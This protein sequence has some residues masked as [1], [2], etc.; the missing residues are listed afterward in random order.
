MVTY[1]P[2]KEPR[3]VLLARFDRRYPDLFG[4]RDLEEHQIVKKEEKPRERSEP[5]PE[6]VPSYD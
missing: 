5:Q 6:S 3:D 2:R 4:V 1:K